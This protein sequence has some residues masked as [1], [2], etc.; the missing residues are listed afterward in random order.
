MWL[1]ATTSSLDR[2]LNF[3]G[4]RSNVNVDRFLLLWTDLVA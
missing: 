2:T 3:S 1:T 4:S